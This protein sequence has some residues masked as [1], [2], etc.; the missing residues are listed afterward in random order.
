MYINEIV[1]Q[2]FVGTNA[3]E[4]Q[5]SKA[6]K[7]VTLE[8]ISSFINNITTYKILD[9]EQ[10]HFIHDFVL[11]VVKGLLFLSKIDNICMK[12]FDSWK[13]SQSMF[14]SCKT[15]I[16]EILFCMMKC[17]L[18]KFVLSYVN[19]TISITPTFDLWMNKD[20]LYIFGFV[21]F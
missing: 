6:W 20:A 1:W 19:T 13:D 2:H 7:V 9:E 21:I 16:E 4:K 11:V 17:T 15:L 8:F 3:F 10:K 14:P 5:S 18:E 12:W